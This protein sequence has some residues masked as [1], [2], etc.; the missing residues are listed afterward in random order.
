MVSVKRDTNMNKPRPMIVPNGDNASM[1][2]KF[3]IATD[4][5]LLRFIQK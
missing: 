1:I 5:P 2:L 4:I 3:P